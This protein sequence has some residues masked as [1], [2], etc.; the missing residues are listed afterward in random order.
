[1]WNIQRMPFKVA[2]PHYYNDFFGKVCGDFKERK[3]YSG[4]NSNYDPF[5]RK[6]P[7]ISY[8]SILCGF[9]VFRVLHSINLM[10]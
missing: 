10:G 6:P 5:I 7:H 1:M 2:G 3:C 4:G 8:F 9:W